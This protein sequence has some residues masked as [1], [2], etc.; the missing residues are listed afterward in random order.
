MEEQRNAEA[1]FTGP[2]HVRVGTGGVGCDRPAVHCDHRKRERQK[3]GSRGQR[4]VF[5]VPEFFYGN[6]ERHAQ[7]DRVDHLARP[8]RRGEHRKHRDIPLLHHGLCVSQIQRVAS[9]KE[10][11]P[12]QKSIVGAGC[13]KMERHGKQRHAPEDLFSKGQDP[14]T[15][16]HHR[17]KKQ[18]VKESCQ[19][20]VDRI[21]EYKRRVYSGVLNTKDK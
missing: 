21:V 9:E 4:P 1:L 15:E 13:R 11:G 3:N 17:R 20:L 16:T 6:E 10:A 19:E 18:K 5:P 7:H 2:G 8:E 14:D 12:H